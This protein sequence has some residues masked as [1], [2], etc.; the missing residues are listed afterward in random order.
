MESIFI[1]N[2][3]FLIFCF[4]CV[5]VAEV[6][7]RLRFLN[8]YWGLETANPGYWEEAF[9]KIVEKRRG[10]GGIRKELY[11]HLTFLYF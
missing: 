3:N 1:I 4:L 6:A 10:Q 11:H 2:C 5:V 7:R 8:E 9:G